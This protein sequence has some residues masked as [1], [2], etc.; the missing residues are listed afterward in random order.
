MTS[1][2]SETQQGKRKVETLFDRYFGSTPEISAVAPG[3]LNL[4]GEHTDYND[5]FVF[6]VAID[7]QVW[8]AAKRTKGPSR[9]FSA[10]LDECEPFDANQVSP[11][12]ARGWSAYAAGMAWA[13]RDKTARPLPN[14]QAVVRSDVP[15]G[16]GI[17]SSAA[18]EL[19]FGVVWNRLAHFDLSA[20]ELAVA[21]RACEN[22]FVGVNSGIMDQMASALGRQGQAMFLDTKTLDVRYATVPSDLTI[23]LCDTGKPRQLADS[24]YNDRRAECQV[25]CAALGVHSL[26]EAT[27]TSVED[28]KDSMDEPI[29]RR[30]RHV[31]TENER[32]KSF[33]EALGHKD[34]ARIGDLMRQS[35]ESLRD[36]YEVSC[37]ELD[38]MAESAWE[39]EGCVGARMTGAGFGGACVALVRASLIADFITQTAIQYKKKTG[40]GGN[41]MA[42]RAEDGA[43]T[44]SGP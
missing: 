14:I 8:I 35:H 32:C 28:R 22:R 39:A 3:R 44:L 21:G 9:I 27:P 43:R 1:G 23:A 2:S 11:G 12:D 10:E 7:R 37:P 18:L 6:P 31:V 13:L 17:G 24:A 34:F 33:Y 41:F 5:G 19:A 30:A 40:L 20:K 36:D 25:A 38:A 29:Y 15:I 26:R 42:C 4:I 16:G